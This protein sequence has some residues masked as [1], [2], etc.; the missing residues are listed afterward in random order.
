M[1]KAP[2]GV[3]VAKPA[4]KLQVVVPSKAQ[5]KVPLAR[6]GI[7]AG[8]GFVVGVLWPWLAGVKLVPSA[9]VE[10]EKTS[11][12][13][14]EPASPSPSPTPAP[15]AKAAPA[16]TAEP[17][18]EQRVQ[19]GPPIYLNCLDKDG[20]KLKRCDEI[21]FT[22]VAKARIQSLANCPGADGAA[23]TFSIG[24]K[25]SFP[26][27]KVVKV[28]RGKSTT[29]PDDVTAVLM[30]CAEKEFASATLEG[31][32]HEH[33]EYVIFYKAEFFPPGS[34]PSAAGADAG[35]P[36][37]KASGFA[38]VSWNVAL[39]RDKPE[40]G[41]VVARILRGTRVKVTGRQDDWYRV[42]YDSKGGEGWVFK[43]AV[44]L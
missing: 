42:K 19:V 41:E 20:R 36:V 3:L 4:E 21:D 32:E 28:M 34:S 18:P 39:I 8:V 43:G 33:V 14:S 17:T 22:A 27:K 6:V 23:G 37:T 44:G 40:D 26:K 25:L 15:A 1:L 31:V 5:D 29:L 9:P 2:E 7:I 10:G 13:V 30:T 16:K 35:P 24:F 38:T 12:V 11:A